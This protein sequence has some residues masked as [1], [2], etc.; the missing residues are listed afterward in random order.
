M[1]EEE[2]DQVERRNDVEKDQGH[3]EEGARGK[4]EESQG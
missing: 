1:A 4:G 3:G 2:L